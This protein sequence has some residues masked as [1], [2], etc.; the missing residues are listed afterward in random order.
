M[1]K[2]FIIAIAIFSCIFIGCQNS[3][4][5]TD[6][7]IIEETQQDTPVVIDEDTTEEDDGTTETPVEDPVVDEDPVEEDTPTEEIENP[8]TNEDPVEDPV[9]DE[10]VINDDPVEEDTP[11]EDDPINNDPVVDEPTE[12][13]ETPENNQEVIETNKIETI[14]GF[15]AIRIKEIFESIEELTLYINSI[16]FRYLTAKE[17]FNIIRAEK[18]MADLFLKEYGIYFIYDGKL[19]YLKYVGKVHIYDLPDS[20]INLMNTD[21]VYE[22]VNK[23]DL[24]YKV[25]Y[26]CYTVTDEEDPF[27]EYDRYRIVNPIAITE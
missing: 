15:Y 22:T 13:E 19:R 27:V 9:V 12:E 17:L 10:P 21:F 26:N 3:D 18:S 6:N 11:T 5:S 7:V 25:T 20:K 16:D 24:I 8:S 23:D 2:F 1:K 14:Y 4:D